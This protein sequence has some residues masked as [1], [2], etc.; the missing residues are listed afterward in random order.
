MLQKKIL[1]K[2]IW[3]PVQQLYVTIWIVTIK[4]ISTHTAEL[5]PFLHLHIVPNKGLWWKRFWFSCCSPG[6]R[7]VLQYF[8]ILTNLMSL[9][10]VYE[11][12]SYCIQ[13]KCSTKT[14]VLRSKIRDGMLFACIWFKMSLFCLNMDYLK[15][16]LIWFMP[17][18][19]Q[20]RQKK[21]IKCTVL[22]SFLI[23]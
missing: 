5:L 21:A 13:Y 20:Y 14:F 17:L 9:F 6:C 4:K 23:Y 8:N 7:K 10:S 1:K 2:D 15:S 19:V 12:F 11:F 16:L 3:N 22:P 18:L